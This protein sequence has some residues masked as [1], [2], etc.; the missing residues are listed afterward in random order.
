MAHVP[1]LTFQ[2]GNKSPSSLSALDTVFLWAAQGLVSSPAGAI[3]QSLGSSWLPLGNLD[4][5][6]GPAT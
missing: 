2:Q 5:S 6:S 3:S 4:P 1:W